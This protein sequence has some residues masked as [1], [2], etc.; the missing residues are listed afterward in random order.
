[1]III[2]EDTDLIIVNKP[3]FI[4]TIPDRYDP[5]K[6]NLLTQLR[7]KY[8]QVFTVHRL[9]KETSGIICFARNEA[10]HRHLSQ[11][12]EA[13]TVKKVYYALV[14][15]QPSE[16]TGII[17]KPIAKSLTQ[18]GKMVISDRGKP[19]ETHYK[20]AETF[21][22]YSLL[23]AEIKTG[24]THQIRVHLESIGLPLMIDEIYG[25]KS[26][27]YVSE[28]KLKRYNLGRG[29]EERPLMSRSSLHAHYL[30]LEHPTSG[31]RMT[32]QATLPKDFGAVVKQLRKWGK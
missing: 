6:P 10:A 7:R 20:V 30:E 27:F 12:F 5:T 4:L 28:I 17:N 15:G 23:E 31:E 1:M 18:N 13:R 2:H 8:E 29:K 24:R 14:E 21:K 26:A 9:D 25:R 11:Q 32:F 19:S 3:P 16:P 22:H